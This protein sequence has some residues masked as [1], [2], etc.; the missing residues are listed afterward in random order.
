MPTETEDDSETETMG[1]LVSGRGPDWEHADFPVPEDRMTA[2]PGMAGV[3][4]EPGLRNSDCSRV[5]ATRETSREVARAAAEELVRRPKVNARQAA[6][7][8]IASTCAAAVG[9]SHR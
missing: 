9:V 4:L 6:E 8:A 3:E 5:R 2:A 1:A 7:T